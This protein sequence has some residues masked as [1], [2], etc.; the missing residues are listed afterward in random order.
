MTVTGE[1]LWL[2]VVLNYRTP[3]TA[4]LTAGVIITIALT[5]YRY[6][7]AGRHPWQPLIYMPLLAGAYLAAEYFVL[8]RLLAHV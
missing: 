6:R 5:I 8:D 3:A 4:F 7:S 1:G 2:A